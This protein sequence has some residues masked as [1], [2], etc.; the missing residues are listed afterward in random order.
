MASG[1]RL[2]QSIFSSNWHKES[3]PTLPGPGG[4]PNS[5]G[6]VGQ[7]TEDGGAST[8]DCPKSAIVSK[9]DQLATFRRVTGIDTANGL[10]KKTLYG[11]PADN[12]GIYSRVVDAEA[13][14]RRQYLI[15]SV[16][17]NGCLGLQIVVAAALTALGAGKGPHGAVTAFG[18]INTIIAGFLTY[19]NGSG[20]PNRQ[21]YN[22]HEWSKLREYIEQRERE[23]CREGFV[24]DINKE[25]KDVEMMYDEVKNDVE[26]N[27][28][29]SFISNSNSKSNKNALDRKKRRPSTPSPTRHGRH[30]SITPRPSGSEGIP[31]RHSTSKEGFTVVS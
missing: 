5:F 11:R 24:F 22:A 17:I 9:E 7:Q 28:P 23:F 21:K 31:P 2:F 4:H 8:L 10:T 13:Y 15:F 20:L 14:A 25:L 19:L 27:Q 26:A 6:S 12:V 29:D 1:R 16:L 3:T 18:A 30:D